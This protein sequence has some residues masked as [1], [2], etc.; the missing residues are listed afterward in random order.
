M[1][2]LRTS[3]CFLG[4]T[5]LPGCLPDGALFFS[6]DIFSILFCLRFLFLVL[7]LFLNETLMTQNQSHDTDLDDGG[8]ALE[9]IHDAWTWKEDGWTAQVMANDD[10]GWAVSMTRDGESEP[11]LVGPW[12]MGRNKKD[13]KPLDGTAFRTLVKTAAEVIRRHEQ[14][15]HA[16]LHR[17]LTVGVGIDA[18]KVSLD[19]IPDEDDPHAILSALNCYGEPLGRVRVE[20]TFKLTVASAT[21]WIQKDFERP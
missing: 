7:F 15:L 13:P 8:E 9:V 16:R 10:E 5:D 4:L 20:P 2:F 17:D 6:R 19:I 12:T 1:R 3:R 14:Q 18:V 11:A 21:A